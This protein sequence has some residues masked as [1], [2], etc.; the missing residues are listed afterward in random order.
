MRIGRTQHLVI[1]RDSDQGF[2]LDG[3]ELGEILLPGR[4]I[5]DDVEQGDEVEVFVHRDSEDR[6][7]ATTRKP[8][9]E[10]GQF[11]S[12]EVVDLHPRIGAFLDW[13]LAK[14]LL[15]PFREQARRV[16][17]GDRVVV[18]VFVDPKSERLLATT[19]FHRFFDRGRPPCQRGDK[20]SLLVTEETPLGWLAV[21]DQAHRGRLHR[22]EADRPPEIGETLEG[23]VL[24]LRPDGN[25]DLSL[26]PPGAARVEGLVGQI[27]DRLHREGGRMNLGDRSPPE[28]I[29]EAF[30]CS[31][32]AFKKALG[33]LYRE[34]KVVVG[35]EGAELAGERKGKKDQA[36]RKHA[37]D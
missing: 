35:E 6:L 12:L 36:S 21:V 16:R 32:K 10:A 17:A 19:K 20:V 27:L 28:E 26:H 30:G 1:T 31:K 5:P 15:L 33:T 2:Y 18:H 24:A 37:T 8:L 3:G 29:R 14:E 22:S 23:Y 34:R 25:L 4:E 7:V 9:C 11:A 13:G